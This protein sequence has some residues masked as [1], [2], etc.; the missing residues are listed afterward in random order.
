MHGEIGELVA[1][2]VGPRRA[3][4]ALAADAVH[5][6]LHYCMAPGI[7][8]EGILVPSSCY[9]VPSD[10]ALGMAANIEGVTTVMA[11]PRAA[12]AGRS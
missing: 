9:A 11:T 3:L 4:A 6:G 2:P 5:R 7:D 8:G 10:R 12:S 1:L